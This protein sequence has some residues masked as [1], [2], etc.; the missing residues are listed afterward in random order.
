M[1]RPRTLLKVIVQTRAARN[2]ILGFRGDTL[3]VKVTPPP[4]GGKANA[5]VLELV[6]K[7]LK[8]PKSSIR[9]IRGHTSREKLMAIEELSPDDFRSR[10]AGST[11][12]EL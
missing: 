2:E 1:T 3:Q 5:A 10:L 4:E 7:A 12:D 6:A 11:R 9:L 8:V